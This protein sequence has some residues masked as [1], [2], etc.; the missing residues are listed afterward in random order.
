MVVSEAL[1][2][3][4]PVITTAN[5]GAAD[6]IDEGRNGFLVPP[7]NAEALSERLAWCLE[8]P[9]EIETMRKAALDKA[10]QWSWTDFRWKLRSQL[11]E[12]FDWDLKVELPEEYHERFAK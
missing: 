2:R 7:R 5:A 1:S 9:W 6:L 8:N 3:G 12:S 10:L 11:N 4:L